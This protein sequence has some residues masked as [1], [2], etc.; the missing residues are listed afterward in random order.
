MIGIL[1]KIFIKDCKNYTDENVRRHYGELTSIFG[2]FLNICLFAGKFIIGLLTNAI[3]IIAD[4]FNNLS[5]A[6]SS[7]ITLFGFKLSKHEPDNEHPFGH[8]R[9]EYLSGLF[10][11]VIIILMAFELLKSS[12][13]K[14]FV[15]EETVIAPVTFIILTASILVKIYMFLYNKKYG[16]RIN[17]S[18]MKAT[19][20]DSLSDTISTSVVLLCS[21]L[22]FFYNFKIDAY[23]G[24]VVGLFIGYTGIKTLH[25]TVSPLL[26]QAPD[27][28]L[29]ESVKNI[30]LEDEIICG[31]H[32]MI[33]HNYGPTRTFISLHAEVPSDYDILTIHD[34]ID[35][36][37]MKIKKELG[38]ETTIHMD[39]VNT[40]DEKTK[41]CK[42]AVTDI[43]GTID[44]R[45]SLHDFRMVHG[46]S[47]SN[48]LF[49]LVIP[50][51]FDLSN[52]E[53]KAMIE[54]KLQKTYP[55]YYCVIEFDTDYT[56]TVTKKY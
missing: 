47:H 10:V 20:M 8:G 11:A 13:Q 34:S 15:P 29:V 24:I 41:E 18:A 7:I 36:I 14:V 27:P 49:D 26:G 31:I 35:S 2:I 23:A 37:E 55:N 52:A 30:V 4:A 39:P 28:E 16:K 42:K 40:K 51:K 50:H 32:D 43:I 17:S 54:K 9:F 25:E 33:V 38:I 56:S 21:I 53:L 48:V 46:D 3:S 19:A 12:V 44:T 1:S 22:Q 6:G 5:D 45:L